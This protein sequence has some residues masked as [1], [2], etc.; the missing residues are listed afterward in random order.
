MHRPRFLY[1]VMLVI[2]LYG[3][4]LL[5]QV[6]RPPLAK[7]EHFI[8][9][10]NIPTFPGCAHL[11]DQVAQHQ[12]TSEK[13][14]TFIYD[15]LEYPESARQ[16][17]EEEEVVVQF[18][19]EKDGI[20]K[21]AQVVSGTTNAFEKEGLRLIHLMRTKGYNWNPGPS[22][23]RPI[24]ALFQ[25]AIDFNL[26]GG[27]PLPSSSKLVFIKEMSPG[28]LL[29]PPPPPPP[30]IVEGP[31]KIILATAINEPP[32]FPGCEDL[33]SY[34]KK[35]ACADREMLEF[36]HGNVNIPEIPPET[37]VHGTVVVSFIVERNGRV[38]HVE[39][40]RDIGYGLGAEVVRVINLMNAKGL[41]F[42]PSK[43]GG[44]ASRVRFN[45][46]VNFHFG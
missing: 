10:K 5:G 43:S 6:D 32:I 2:C 3:S 30:P 26:G 46:P 45:I 21:K 24:R 19:V 44:R 12:C 4:S 37:Q 28:E 39:I 40:V 33:G 31:G 41:K 1:S 20:V 16:N 27:R 29:S 17:E 38:S 35:K 15:N 22:V 25:V 7:E 23:G 34:A 11:T 42:S 13:L 8:I 36:I 14:L 9:V 18:I